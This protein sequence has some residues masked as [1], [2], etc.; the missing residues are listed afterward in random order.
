M[1]LTE[2]FLCSGMSGDGNGSPE[3]LESTAISAL[4]SVG[5][6]AATEAEAEASGDEESSSAQQLTMVA[7]VSG[8]HDLKLKVIFCSFFFFASICG[9]LSCV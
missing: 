9:D 4:R 7:F 1:D 8:S 6:P 5:S 2:F 3:S